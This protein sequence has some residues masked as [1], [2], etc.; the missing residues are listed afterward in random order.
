MDVSY[1]SNSLP[2]H[3]DPGNLPTP[4]SL[5]DD[6]EQFD[7]IDVQHLLHSN[8]PSSDLLSQQSQPDWSAF[9][10]PTTS[11][12]FASSALTQT[13]ALQEEADL[14]V[15]SNLTPCSL[16][17][18][19]VCDSWPSQTFCDTH[20]A[21]PEPH[22]NIMQAK[23]S[24]CGTSHQL[25]GISRPQSRQQH[26]HTSSP[27]LTDF[28]GQAGN[29]VPT[30]QRNGMCQSH[31]ER[32]QSCTH[33][34]RRRLSK[35]ASPNIPRVRSTPSP[36]LGATPQPQTPSRNHSLAP[37]QTR[38]ND[39]PN[40]ANPGIIHQASPLQPVHTHCSHCSCS[41]PA[42][43]TLISPR[44]SQQHNSAPTSARPSTQKSSSRDLQILSDCGLALQNLAQTPHSKT[45]VDRRQSNSG[46]DSDRGNSG[47]LADSSQIASQIIVAGNY[48]GIQDRAKGVEKVVILYM[49]HESDEEMDD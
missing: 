15:G 44:S 4:T 5:H 21:T 12:A 20:W 38:S 2:G 10:V 6:Y 13:P 8:D 43:P 24:P 26:D 22:Q 33:N 23:D 45:R 35:L 11:N 42:R 30:P 1:S 25:N 7:A 28:G 39:E 40:P 18:S 41:S 14:S 31:H 49:Q 27:I 16:P 32:R 48:S 29:M 3:A 17:T 46:D 19:S 37:V 9:S 47:T 36:C 34:H